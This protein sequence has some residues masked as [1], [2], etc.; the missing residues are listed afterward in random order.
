[1]VTS[2]VLYYF[3]VSQIIDESRTGTTEQMKWT[4]LSAYQIVS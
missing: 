3:M 1:M 4:V 2:C